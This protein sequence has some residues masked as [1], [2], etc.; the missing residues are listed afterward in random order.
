MFCNPISYLQSLLEFGIYQQGIAVCDDL[1]SRIQLYH[2]HLTAELVCELASSFRV[3][4]ADLCHLASPRLNL[5]ILEQRAKCSY[6]TTKSSA[7]LIKLKDFI[8][9]CQLSW[10]PYLF[11]RSM[12]L[13][14][15]LSI[16]S[17]PCREIFTSSGEI[18]KLSEFLTK[19]AGLQIRACDFHHTRLLSESALCYVY[20][21]TEPSS[22]V[23]T[24]WQ[25]L[26]NI[27]RFL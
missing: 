23:F 16:F 19:P 13:A 24:S 12:V 7:Y 20:F 26:C 25:C 11:F 6:I 2:P 8:L 5:G 22:V 10:R 18:I 1:R 27:W 4:V 3:L 14:Y 9:F 21:T 17:S 15:S